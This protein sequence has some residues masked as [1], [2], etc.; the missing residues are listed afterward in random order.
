MLDTA[1]DGGFEN[2]STDSAIAFRA[3]LSAMARPGTIETLDLAKGPKPLSPAAA[4]LLLTLCDGETPVW[5]A[6][7]FDTP[8]LRNWIAFHTGAPLCAAKDAQFA[9][10]TWT[11]L[12]PLDA[13]SIGTAQY[14]DRSTTLIVEMP[15]LTPSGTRLSGPGIKTETCL[16]LPSITEYQHNHM[17]FP[18]GLDFFFT[19]GTD[20]A[21]LPR[22]TQVEAI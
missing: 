2:P 8:D 4:S 9:I 7:D 5:L 22:S 10:G 19:A 3:A 6:P 21:A 15:T 18:R 17:F 16:S 12:L 14:P 13:Y 20:L 11:H 1:L